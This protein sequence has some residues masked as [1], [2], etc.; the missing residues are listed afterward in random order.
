MR[1]KVERA[2]SIYTVR[3]SQKL[4]NIIQENAKKRNV[5]P[6]QYIAQILAEKLFGDDK[7]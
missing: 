4:K 7:K 1:K 5:P 3:V 2:S 6:A